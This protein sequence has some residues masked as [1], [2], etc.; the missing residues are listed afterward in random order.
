MKMAELK[1]IQK[2]PKRNKKRERKG[3]IIERDKINLCAPL[4]LHMSAPPLHN[5][6][7]TQP[8][9]MPESKSAQA[10]S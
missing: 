9:Q 2:K 8:S 5:I 3:L 10:R 4:Y 1:A 7:V 6:P